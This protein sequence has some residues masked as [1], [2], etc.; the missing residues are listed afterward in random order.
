MVTRL[1]YAI[2][3]NGGWTKYQYTFIPVFILKFVSSRKKFRYPPVQIQKSS[4]N[5]SKIAE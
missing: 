1:R 5:T 2:D 3:S 4:G